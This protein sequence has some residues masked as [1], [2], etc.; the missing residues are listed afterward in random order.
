MPRAITKG[1]P[2]PEQPQLEGPDVA[3]TDATRDVPIT[4]RLSPEALEAM[5]LGNYA[6]L[7]AADRVQLI[8]HRCRS[9]G[10]D[11]AAI[12]FQFI[13]LQGRLVM[14]ATKA[15][16]DMLRSNRRIDVIKSESK[17]LEDKV[18]IVDVMLRDGEG[19]TDADVG[20]VNIQGLRGD[21]LANAIMKAHTKAKRRATLSLCGLGMLDESELETI[22]G[23]PPAG[24]TAIPSNNTGHKSGKYVDPASERRWMAT[25]DKFIAKVNA[26]WADDISAK[27]ISLHTLP[28]GAQKVLNDYGLDRHLLN[29]AAD[30]GL[31]ESPRVKYVAED[32]D[33][34]YDVGP[35]QCPK[36]VAVAYHHDKDAVMK[37]CIEYANKKMVDLSVEYHLGDDVGESAET[38]D[39]EATDEE[40]NDEWTRQANELIDEIYRKTQVAKI[41]IADMLI[42]YAIKGKHIGDP[43]EPDGSLPWGSAVKVVGSA[44]MSGMRKDRAEMYVLNMLKRKDGATQAETT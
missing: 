16:T 40:I 6:K 7:D 18:Y 15:C 25:R 8:L 43:Y 20:V 37:E 22:Q 26:R 17:F 39:A 29:W 28:A 9:V 31:I 13:D 2:M 11:P 42:S 27:G 32:G 35:A 10:L 12:P 24:Q 41:M 14:Y 30:T 19:R 5:V 1:R 34:V 38:I 33:P 44:L 3:E 21:Q 23:L 36:L 4:E